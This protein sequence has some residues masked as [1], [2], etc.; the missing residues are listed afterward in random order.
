VS[1]DG[2]EDPPVMVARNPELVWRACAKSFSTFI[3]CQVW[4]H[5]AIFASEETARMLAQAQDVPLRGEDLALLRDRF[6]ERTMTYGWP[7]DRQYRFESRRAAL[8]LWSDPDRTDWWISSGKDD[9]L[10]DVTRE[11][12]QCGNLRSSLW[13]HQ[14]RGEKVLDRVRFDPG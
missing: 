1:L 3:E 11:L 12:W 10:A 13:S 7:A 9:H 6:V 2:S 4:D 5:T 8:L 14:E